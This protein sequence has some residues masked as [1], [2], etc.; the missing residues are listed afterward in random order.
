MCSWVVN[1]P[2]LNILYNQLTSNTCVHKKVIKKLMCTYS[3]LKKETIFA[4]NLK[5]VLPGLV[6]L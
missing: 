5:K 4:A 2:R 1:G 3:A 6:I